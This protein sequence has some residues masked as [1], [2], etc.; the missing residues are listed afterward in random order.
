MEV[1]DV[2]SA[3]RDSSAWISAFIDV[4]EWSMLLP[5]A[6]RPGREELDCE[7]ECWRWAYSAW[8]RLWRSISFSGLGGIG[9]ATRGVSEGVGNVRGSSMRSG[10]GGGLGFACIGGGCWI[11]CL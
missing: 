10:G 1:L 8:A 3:E 11:C 5:W 9:G 6:R 2:R 4:R 7:R